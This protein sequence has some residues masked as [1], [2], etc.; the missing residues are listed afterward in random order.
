MA[1]GMENACAIGM[2]RG[3]MIAKVPHELPVEKDTNAP[4]RKIAAGTSAAEKLMDFSTSTINCAVPKFTD[5]AP[6][7]PGKN[8]G[9]CHIRH[10]FH[11]AHIHLECL[12]EIHDL[13]RQ[14]IRIRTQRPEKSIP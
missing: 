12:A 10:P 4:N 2:A 5:H 1:N 9:D 14:I 7:G 8:Q 13:K 6:Q 11:T 3:I